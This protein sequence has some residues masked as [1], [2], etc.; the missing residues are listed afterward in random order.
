MISFVLFL[1]YWISETWLQNMSISCQ[2]EWYLHCS[3]PPPQCP[4]FFSFKISH[5]WKLRNIRIPCV[6]FKR[7]YLDF[8]RWMLVIIEAIRVYESQMT[9]LKRVSPHW[10]PAGEVLAAVMKQWMRVSFSAPLGHS[11]AK[12]LFVV[13][14]LGLNAKHLAKSSTYR[15]CTGLPGL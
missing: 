11:L 12:H 7:K 1:L 2:D 13:N 8:H 14:N 9:C 15:W 5:Q 3:P 10:H 4:I 6:K